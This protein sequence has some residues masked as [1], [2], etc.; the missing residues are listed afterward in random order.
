MTHEE[1]IITEQISNVLVTTKSLADAIKLSEFENEN[2]KAVKES[3]YI[4]HKGQLIRFVDMVR[5][6]REV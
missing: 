5:N 1:E 6:G 3:F 4:N 2:E